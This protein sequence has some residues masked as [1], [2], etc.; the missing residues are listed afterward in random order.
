MSAITRGNISTRT[1]PLPDS[2]NDSSSLVVTGN[3]VKL[4]NTIKCK[5]LQ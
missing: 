4:S 2:V 5:R 3:A 1:G